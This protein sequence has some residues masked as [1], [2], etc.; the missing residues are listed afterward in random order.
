MTHLLDKA[1][2]AASKLPERE[3]DVLAVILHQE[4]ASEQ[5][6][7]EA[8]VKSQEALEELATEALAEHA[9]GRTKPF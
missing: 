6:W 3:Q 2:S 7:S 9:A 8:F 4:I 1:I 5:W